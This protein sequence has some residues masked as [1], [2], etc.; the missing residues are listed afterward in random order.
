[1]RENVG[2]PHDACVQDVRRVQSHGDEGV[3]VFLV[4]HRVGDVSLN[5]VAVDV[6]G[7]QLDLAVWVFFLK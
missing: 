4:V 5:G 3:L 7:N 6:A 1:M 2:F